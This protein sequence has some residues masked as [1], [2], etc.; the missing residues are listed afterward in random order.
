[1]TITWHRS[2]P[3]EIEAEVR[4]L[5]DRYA[6]LI[7]GWMRE[8]TVRYAVDTPDG[9]YVADINIQPE[10]RQATLRLVPKWRD[11]DAAFKEQ[12]IIHELIHLSLAPMDAWTQTLITKT[13]PDEGLR[14][15]LSEDWRRAHEGATE[16]LSIAV[17]ASARRSAD[18]KRR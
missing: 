7:P 8:L 13:V 4:P 11:C 12:T 6:Y 17:Y 14:D 2:L 18:K 15:T 3:P 16:D 9:S 5:V 1:M 10:Y